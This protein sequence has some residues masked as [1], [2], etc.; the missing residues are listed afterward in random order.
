MPK[1]SDMIGRLPRLVAVIAVIGVLAACASDEAD[2]EAAAQFEEG[3]VEQLYN[4]AMDALLAGQAQQA[5]TQFEEV[6]RQHP[7]SVWATKAQLMTAYSSY[8]NGDYGDAIIALDRYIQL[9]PGNRDVAYAY[10]LKALSYYRQV[11]DVGRDQRNTELALEAFRELIRR[12]PQSRYTSDARHKVDL[13]VNHLAGKEMEV[14]RFYQRRGDYLA[15]VNRFRIVVDRY[16]TTTQV[17]EALHRLAE[18]YTAMGLK[19]EAERVAAVLGYNYP[20]SSWYFDTY[21]LVA[22]VAVEGKPEDPV[23]DEGFLSWLF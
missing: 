5:A 16:D 8:Q 23:P 20:G 21:E 10:Y 18:C 2:E 9:H 4:S 13:I 11:T 14:G 6:E 12:F 19:P 15:A 17:P 22:G 1:L 7:Y 3:S